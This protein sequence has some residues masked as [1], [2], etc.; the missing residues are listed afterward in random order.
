MHFPKQSFGEPVRRIRQ[1]AE[2]V[3]LTNSLVLRLLAA[4]ALAAAQA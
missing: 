4:M 2:E 1:L 3:D